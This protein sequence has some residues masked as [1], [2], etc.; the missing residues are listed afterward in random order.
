M[1]KKGLNTTVCPYHNPYHLDQHRNFQVDIKCA[2]KSAM[3]AESRFVL[4][5]DQAFYYRKANPSYQPLPPFHPNCTNNTFSSMKF[6]YPFSNSSVYVSVELDVDTGK[7]VFEIA[8]VNP[9]T[10][11]FWHLN[12]QYLGDTKNFHQLSVSPKAGKYNLV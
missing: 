7:T 2:E 5:P 8:H 10:K 1:P 12:E 6:I 3:I 11:I 9:S 4:P